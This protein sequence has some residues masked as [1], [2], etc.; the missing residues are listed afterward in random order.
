MTRNE[1]IEWAKS[2]G[3]QEDRYG[4]LQKTAPDGQKRMK[5]SRIAVRY[6]KKCPHG[7]VRVLS[8]YYSKL[9]ATPDGKLAGLAR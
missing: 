8:G 3:Y 2:H 4:H 6:E 9:S 7:W 5:L 1:F